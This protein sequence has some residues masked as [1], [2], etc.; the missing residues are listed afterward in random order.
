MKRFILSNYFRIFISAIALLLGIRACPQAF[1][2]GINLNEVAS[3]TAADL[4]KYGNIPVSYYTGK[5]NISI[6]IYKLSVRGFDFPIT[7]TYDGSGVLVNSLPG[8]TGHSWTLLAGGVISR[9]KFG[10]DDEYAVSGRTANNY[11]KYYNI[12]PKYLSDKNL[13]VN[14]S[15]FAI[16][17]CQPDVFTFNILGRTGSFFLG[18]D[19]EWKVSCDENIEVLFD[20]ENESNYTYPFI[21]DFPGGGKQPKTIKQFMLRDGDGYVYTFGGTTD[22]IEYST[23]FFYQQSSQQTEYLHAISWY[24]TS[25]KDRLGNLLYSLTYKRGKFIAQLFHEGSAYSRSYSTNSGGGLSGSYQESRSN[26]SFPY[27]GTL[28]APVYLKGCSK[29]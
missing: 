1:M 17:D 26:K 4:G 13:L 5:A 7:L 2:S 8:W 24:L 20:I 29:N 3:P 6:P 9:S 21:E 15:V 14:H 23:D 28:N 22:A 11:F 25:I 18:N 10:N 19:G 27:S 12:P 16:C